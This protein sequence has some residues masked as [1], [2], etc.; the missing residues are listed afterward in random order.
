M[1][2][3]LEPERRTKVRAVISFVAILLILGLT[4][5]GI[6]LLVINKRVAKQEA[7]ERI[8]PSVEVADLTETT[9][10][11]MLETQGVIESTRQSQLAAEVMGRIIEIS[12]NLKRGGQVTEGEILAKIDPADYRSALATA[13]VALKDAELRLTQEKARS[14]QA[15]LDWKRLGRGNTASPL[16]LRQPQL[17]AAEAQVSSAQE[18]ILRAQRNLERTE[19]TAPF[20][21]GIRSSMIEVGAVTSPGTIIAELYTSAELEARLPLSLQDFGFLKQSPADSKPQDSTSEVT[22]SGKIGTR[23]Y[24][25]PAQI[26][27]IDPEIERKTLSATIVVKV[28]P[29]DNEDFPLP[30]VG[31]FVDAKVQGKTLSEVIE[32][33]RRALLEGNRIITVDAQNKIDFA[34]T[35]VIRLTD[36]TAIVHTGLDEE[37]R[38]VL[39][40]LPAPVS[41]MEVQIATSPT[42]SK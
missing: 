35:E 22:L 40:R 10:P 2:P 11:V 4:A 5:G 31:L 37:H 41:G 26:V 33:P 14:E 17:A 18:E 36:K 28:L 6:M 8:V 15:Q 30:P 3:S 42:S 9:H 27:R 1:N 23:V 13:Q 21:G 34:T 7:N 38:L 25:W 32:I 20:T 19:I 39:T 12:P 16:V 29:S 24:S